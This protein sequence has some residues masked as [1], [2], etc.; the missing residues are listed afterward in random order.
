[1]WMDGYA[2]CFFDDQ[3]EKK[4]AI[5]MFGHCP[6]QACQEFSAFI[7]ARDYTKLV[8][9]TTHIYIPWSPAEI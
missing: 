4:E 9:Q 7:R 5:T 8:C 3:L 6:A 1:M 2:L